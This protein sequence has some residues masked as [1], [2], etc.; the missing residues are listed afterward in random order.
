MTKLHNKTY[1][2]YSD[3]KTQYYYINIKCFLNNYNFN[4]LLIN[5]IHEIGII[6][7]LIYSLVHRNVLVL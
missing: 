5:F 4:A 1:D 6:Q 7:L 3:Y 2:K